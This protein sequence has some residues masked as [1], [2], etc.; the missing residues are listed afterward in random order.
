ME[1]QSP[2]RRSDMRSLK[3]FGALLAVTALIAIGA[4][5]ASAEF[6][7]TAPGSITGTQ[8]GTHTFKAGSTVTCKKVDA[9]GAIEKVFGSS[10]EVTVHYSE[11][12]VDGFNNF[13]HVSDA[14]Y[15][16]TSTGEVDVHLLNTVTITPTV[17]GSSACTITVTPQTLNTVDY[18]NVAGGG[19]TV[20]PTITGISY[21]S[22]GGLCGPSGSVGTYSGS[23]IVNGTAGQTLSVDQ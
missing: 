18:T 6:T 5:T 20:N 12:T 11:C 21:H 1:P 10:Q 23:S 9:T 19:V 4:A 22:T 13:A 3:L 17:F 15:T 14:T 16:F 2:E 8:E 7:Y